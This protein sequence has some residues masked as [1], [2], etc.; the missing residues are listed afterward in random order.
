MFDWR[1]PTD[2]RYPVDPIF[3]Q[4]Q[5][6]QQQQILSFPVMHVCA[7]GCLLLYFQSFSNIQ[8]EISSQK[9]VIKVAFKNKTKKSLPT[10]PYCY[11]F[12]CYAN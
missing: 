7:G 2:P 3:Q 1:N 5:Q 11:F 10:Y 8:P 4:Q 9:E 12:L 6:Q